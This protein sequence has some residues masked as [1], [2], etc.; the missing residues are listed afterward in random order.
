MR[1]LELPI[2]IARDVFLDCISIVEDTDLKARLTACAGLITDAATEF[3][4]KITTNLA[5][6][7]ARETVVNGN[8]SAKELSNV[9]TY[10]MAK[11]KT[12]GRSLYEKLK[13]AADNDICPICGHRIVTNLD[14]YMPK[15]LYPR[16]SVVPINLVPVCTDC[17]K[18][19]L[20]DFP[21]SPQEVTLH[22]YYDN[23][24]NVQWLKADIVEKSPPAVIYS[25]QPH[26]D[27]DALLSQ[28]VT[29]HFNSFEINQLYSKQAAVELT[30]INYRLQKLF[31]DKGVIGVHQ[32]L[33]E[34]AESAEHAN[35]NSWQT[36]LYRCLAGSLWFCDGGFEF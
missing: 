6:T 27:W 36:A 7:I 2:E 4:T 28:R 11:K 18:I 9:Y 22:P 15:S 23:I 21:M 1:K 20:H 35:K 12:P 16:L 14:H 33:Q 25:V 5:H 3:N 8:L 26:T 24:E 19:K 17:N 30:N 34:A 29:N 13:S 31:D 32:H 10:R